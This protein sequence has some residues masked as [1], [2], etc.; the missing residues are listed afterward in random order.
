MLKRGQKKLLSFLIVTLNLF[1][2]FKIVQRE[3]KWQQAHKKVWPVLTKSW[4]T[5]SKIPSLKEMINEEQIRY[6]NSIKNGLNLVNSIYNEEHLIL[7]NQKQV[8]SLRESLLRK[9]ARVEDRLRKKAL[10]EQEMKNIDVN[11]ENQ[12]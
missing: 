7:K 5:E 6:N 1:V 9:K 12:N 11:L 8:D 10:E 3:I 2:L 4:T